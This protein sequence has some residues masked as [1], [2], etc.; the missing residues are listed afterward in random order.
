[1]LQDTMTHAAIIFGG[2]STIIGALWLMIRQFVK[3]SDARESSM[4]SDFRDMQ[5][6]QRDVLLKIIE[7]NTQAM[8]DHTRSIEANSVATKEL[9]HE[10]HALR[11]ESRKRRDSQNGVDAG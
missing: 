4:V 1:M 3:A 7:G 6:W 11:I 5:R 8:V 9:K 10:I 2:A